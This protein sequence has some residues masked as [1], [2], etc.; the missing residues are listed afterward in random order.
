MRN[1][2][3]QYIAKISEITLS[4]A[5]LLQRQISLQNEID[6][7]KDLNEE[8]KK[9]I[10]EYYNLLTYTNQ[11]LASILNGYDILERP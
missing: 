10:L 2:K 9:Q 7:L 11:D 3:F 4:R 5:D 8:Y 1:T 6:Q